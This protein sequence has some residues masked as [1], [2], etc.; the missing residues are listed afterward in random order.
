[1]VFCG[2]EQTHSFHHSIAY[3]TTKYS[4]AREYYDCVAIYFAS[5]PLSNTKHEIPIQEA[6]NTMRKLILCLP[7]IPAISEVDYGKHFFYYNLI[8]L[9]IK[10]YW[11]MMR[12]ITIC[13]CYL[14]FLSGSQLSSYS[15]RM[16][17]A[18][19]AL[20]STSLC[21]CGL[22]CFMSPFYGWRKGC[23]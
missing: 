15:G 23:K 7:L 3:F 2:L 16:W 13:E 10:S 17:M 14:A 22:S 1:M 4:T 6:T 5:R 8:F 11:K 12:K 19:L 9:S 20:S 21:L 18:C